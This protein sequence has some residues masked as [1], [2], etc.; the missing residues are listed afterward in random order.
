[1]PTRTSDAETE[2]YCQCC[3]WKVLFKQRKVFLLFASFAVISDGHYS[4][5]NQRDEELENMHFTM[6]SSIYSQL[7]NVTNLCHP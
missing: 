6:T 2:E 3:R 1:M 4:N 5:R 7:S